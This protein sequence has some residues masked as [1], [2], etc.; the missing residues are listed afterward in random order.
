MSKSEF[1]K[2]SHGVYGGK[3]NKIRSASTQNISSASILA[4]CASEIN[5]KGHCGEDEALTMSDDVQN[6]SETFHRVLGI[7]FEENLTRLAT[8]L[9]GQ[10]PS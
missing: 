6:N 5:A 10:V 8:R 3:D 7:F 4:W 9:V 2:A 1:P